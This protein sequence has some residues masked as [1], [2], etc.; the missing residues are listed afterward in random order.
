MPVQR[1]FPPLLALALL[2]ALLSA[3]PVAAVA[4]PGDPFDFGPRQP[5][6][7]P[8]EPA[9]PDRPGA[10]PGENAS[11]PID[12]EIAE[13]AQWPG[14]VGVRAAESLLLRGEEVID[15]LRQVLA[16]EESPSQPGAA[17]VLGRVGEAAHV[18]LILR[19]A[20]RRHNGSRAEVFFEAAYDL[21]PKRAKDW[22]FSFLPLKRP[23]FRQKAT[24]FLLDHVTEEDRNRVV[25]L[26]DAEK[27]AVRVSGL[28]LIEAAQ[29]PDAVDRLIQALADP[30]PEVS[31]TASVQLALREDEGLVEKLNGI[32]VDGL[33]RE[34]S[35]AVLALTDRARATDDTPFTSVTLTELAGRRG[36]LHPDKLPRGAAAVG[37][38]FGA[39]E[40]KDPQLTPLL[41]QTVVDV[42]IDTV[43]GDHFRDFSSLQEPV[44][45]ALRRLS[46]LDLPSTAIAWA[47]WWQT[48]RGRFKAR[49]PL[50][51]VRAEDMPFAYVRFESVSSDGR[52][53]RVT[54]RS[55]DG[56]PQ[57]GEY[58][59]ARDE[60]QALVESLEA[61]GIFQAEAVEKA[62]ADEHVL[63]VLGVLNQ[64]RQLAV[65]VT[66]ERHALLKLRM[67]SLE[68]ANLW[69][70]YRDTDQWP[71]AAE[72]WKQNE[73][74]MADADPE[75]RVLM[76]KAAIVFAWDDLEDEASRAQALDR[77][78]DLQRQDEQTGA[79]SGPE[80]KQLVSAA[81]SA[82]SFG[83]VERRAVEIAIAAERASEV[84][85][86]LVELLANRSEP[87]ART[88]LA[89]LLATGGPGEVSRAFS[90]PRPGLRG[91][92]ARA[93]QDL[94]E[95]AHRLDPAEAK[96]QE[97][98]LK[99]GL[100]VLA[101]DDDALVAIRAVVALQRLGRVDGVEQ[102]ERIY[103]AGDAGTRISVAEALGEMPPTD[104]WP[105]FSLILA[106]PTRTGGGLLR[107][108]ALRGMGRSGHPKAVGLLVFYLLNDANRS[109]RV[110]AGDALAEMEGDEARFALIRALT[111]GEPDE[112]RRA[113]LVD[114]LGRIPGDTVTEVLLA[115]LEDEDRTV[116]D[117]AALRL[118]EHNVAATVPYL[119]AIVRGKLPAMAQAAVTALENISC[120][121]F[122]V[123][124]HEIL[125]AQYERW[126]QQARITSAGQPDRAWFRDAL[127]TRGYDIGPLTPY[128]SGD[129]EPVAV[130][131]LIHALR[132]E[133]AVVR[134]GAAIALRRI[135]GLSMGEVTRS[136]SKRD[137]ERV[138]DEWARWWDRVK[139]PTEGSR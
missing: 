56:T 49:R 131:V 20:A 24:D 7:T 103:R 111:E 32:A 43:G 89:E 37:L 95:Q 134:R 17:W 42:L 2:G 18:P 83:A 82:V 31:R 4:G 87:A 52:R 60:F 108:A 65:P 90:D 29:V 55:E 61:A 8:K 6:Q 79:L 77:L 81:T 46:G 47:T 130:P 123:A 116:A 22:L 67:D 139:G 98:Q 21:D 45:S 115:Y 3:W 40:S 5:G 50:V 99:P 125:A 113:R 59:L 12:R 94:V 9:D 100:E 74:M 132:D 86:D 102:L 121:R 44:F 1:R 33:P 96:A 73:K 10:R 72:W 85:S 127:R 68:E 137:A 27:P 69:Q 106:E 15:R 122:D 51:V 62:R 36:I 112:E 135:T 23:V 107:A 53:R 136:T 101:G 26:L 80:V 75:T 28:R 114:V 48:E 19:A 16:A 126:Y 34:R 92:A 25:R 93:A 119:I 105:F 109:V 38:A 41:D 66:D 133:E 110:A 30:A 91:A 84:R 63:A 128:V 117:I 13:L 14:K 97:A 11:D 39:L 104:A 71:N 57:T 76:L 58:A 70:R 78:E 124:S 138:A 118:A 129:N 64:R 35:Y 88:L 120:V 54:F